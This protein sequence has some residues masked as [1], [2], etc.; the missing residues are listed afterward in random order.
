MPIPDNIE[1]HD[2]WIGII[3]EMYGHNIFINE[4][5]IKYR[6][7]DNNVSKMEHYPVRI[8]IKNRI[9][10]IKELLKEKRNKK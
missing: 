10:L 9:N 4:C 2:Q 3:G 6:R 7:H 5:L 8:M 1:M